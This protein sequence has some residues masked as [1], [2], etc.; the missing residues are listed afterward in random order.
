[1]RTAGSNGDETLRAI[2]RCAADLIAEHGFEAMNLRQLGDRVG[3]TASSLYNY[4][5]SKQD[6]LYGLVR[7]VMEDLLAA[8]SDQVLSQEQTM[9]KFQAFVQLH[10]QF[11]IERKND[12]RIA[13]TELRSLGPRNRQDIVRLRNRYEAILIRLIRQGCREGVFDVVDAKL[14]TLA[15]IPMLTGVA[16][17]YVPGD[18]LTRGAL[19]KGYVGLSLALVG[20]RKR[21]IVLLPVELVSQ[22]LEAF[23]R[24]A[25][26]TPL[27]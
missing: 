14:A 2:R 16:D 24:S 18:R 20:A 10:L 7:T 17:W 15:L 11:H 9:Q 19:L 21:G 1:V 13:S 26:G 25:A 3:L 6:L 22:P 27:V 23:A 4:I 8:V 5:G 12:V